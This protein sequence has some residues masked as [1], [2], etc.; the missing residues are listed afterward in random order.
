MYNNDTSHLYRVLPLPKD[1][2]VGTQA[3]AQIDFH[4]QVM[5]FFFFPES[6]KSCFKITCEVENWS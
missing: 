1:F 5:N 2:H 6:L 4:S 3:Q